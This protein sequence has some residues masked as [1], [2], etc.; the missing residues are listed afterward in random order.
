M[1]SIYK[2]SIKGIRAFEPE[3]D[4]T[5]QFGSPLTLICGQNGCGKTTIIECLKY[6]T[7]GN[8]PPNSKGGA[9][10]HDPSLSSR[11]VVTGQVKLAFRNANGKSMLTTRTVQ[12]SL[13]K[14]K[15]M[16]RGGAAAAAVAAAAGGGS[17]SSSGGGGITF[18]SLEGQLAYIEK[19][20]KTSISSKNAE[21]DSQIPIFLGASP[22]ILDN[23]IFCHQDES[24]WPLSE[25]SVLKKKFDDIFEASKFTKVLDN[26]KTIK[27]D[28]SVDI[29]LIEQSVNH[30]KIDKDRAQ[31]VKDK[32]VSMN[33]LVDEYT[34]IISD[35][36]IKIEQKE[37][38]AE[39]LFATNQEFQ[40]TLSDYENLVLKR[41]SFEENIERLEST[42]TML[43]DTDEE[44]FHKQENFA[45]INAEKSALVEKLQNVIEKLDSSLKEK[46]NN[47]NELIRLDGSLKAKK[48]EYETNL[49]KINNIM[50]KHGDLVGLPS[51]QKASS[52]SEFGKTI[53][54]QLISTKEE[55]KEVTTKNKERESLQQEKVQNVNNSI[56]KS[57]QTLEYLDSELKNHQQSLSTL[58]KKLD[59]GS[60]NET[61]LVAKKDDLLVIT[62]SLTAKRNLNE[63]R[64]LDTKIICA[65]EEISKLEFESDEIAKKLV[66]SNKQ[67]EIRSKLTYLEKSVESKNAEVSKILKKINTDY[68][69]QVGCDVD[70]DF[71]ETKFIEKFSELSSNYEEQQRK[72]YSLES[73]LE[74]AKRSKQSAI[75]VRDDN[76]AKINH[77][78][79]DILQV[80]PEDSINDYETIVQDL[81]EDYRNVMEDVNTSEVTKSYG[82]SAL[83][84]AEKN[85]CCLLCKRAFSKSELEDF[86][87]NLRMGFD[88]KKIE[89][90]KKT[91]NEIEREFKET[92]QIGL[93]V[94]AYRECLSLQSTYDCDVDALDSKIKELNESIIAE[95]KKL[96]TMKASVDMAAT[97]RKP[98]SDAT[99]LNLEAQDLELQVDDLNDDLG[100]FNV[101]ASTSEL[102]KQ[103]QNVNNKIR[104]IRQE[105][106]NFTEEK[107]QVQKDIQKLENRFKDTKLVISNLERSLAD[108]Q[109]TKRSIKEIQSSVE[110]TEE[111]ST[112]A[113]E[114]LKNLQVKKD[115][116]SSSLR[117]MQEDINKKEEELRKRVQQVSDLSSSFHFLNNA[118]TDFEQNV[119]AKVE[120]NSVQMRN[121]LEECDFIKKDITKNSNEIKILEKEV[122]D[123]SRIEHNIMANIDYRTQVHRL[124]ECDFQ[125]NSLDIENAQLKKQEYQ[126]Q[127]RRLREELSELTAQHA[128]K[129]GEV[130]QI[131]DQV[132]NVKRELESEYKDVNELYH[133]EWIKL[134]T[135]LLVSNDIQNYS[136]ALDNAIMKYHG[137]KMEDINRILNELWSQT[138]K[139]S[140]ISTIAIKSDVNLQAK[141]NRSYNYRVVMIKDSSELDMR[142]R[143]SAG[144][145]VLASILIRLAL[146][147]CFGANCGMIALDEP[148]TNLDNEN[149][150]ALASALN[151]IIEYRKQQSNFQLIVITHDEKFLTHI[152]GDRFTDH[153]Y[154]I[155]RDE[156]SK[157]RI[158]SLPISRIQDI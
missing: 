137:I 32:S 113:K 17:G 46:T 138:Y 154:K 30:L 143:C 111:K 158:Y 151:R 96:E 94:I 3:S 64:D 88:E 40:K 144:Q 121:V 155:Q 76:N 1:S 123:A 38:E 52:I 131:K 149:A 8:L 102:Q 21:L 4:E 97:L 84:V 83:E 25:A 147:E 63:V 31:K 112:I 45:S 136:K 34:E 16:A 124:D 28:M 33:K 141:G 105:L 65:N 19:G 116:E 18:K 70:I 115:L 145:K 48:S 13:K 47:Y 85:N 80:I 23:V 66:I 139:G 56:L 5:I 98:L 101:I 92:R 77:L 89:E 78:K 7:T 11:I 43:P 142:G 140:D 128:G 72:V 24:L 103:Q 91:A 133:A 119:L 15:S 67:S 60:S 55:Q 27:K 93:K 9:F 99:R 87:K 81:E 86:L 73:E 104:Q 79:T 54:K 20:Q 50:K 75:G 44:L 57:E 100:G 39:N 148:T 41:S 127:S 62:Q 95:T 82:T 58:K 118:I 132:E 36:N 12:A 129:I 37:K 125:L 10:V 53:E 110:A 51:S 49:T 134:Q 61:E 117:Q 122:M 150:E 59:A 157:S 42:I 152:Q 114:E 108:V 156:N 106:N 146:A 120:E 14:G 22:A 26:L 6:A 109:N 69:D 2:L 74:S 29:K 126:E 135:N 90:V 130:K 153:F 107:Y 71:A 35:L 68:K